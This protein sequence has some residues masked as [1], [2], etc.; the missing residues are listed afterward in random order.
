MVGQHSQDVSQI[1]RMA[2]SKGIEIDDVDVDRNTDS[3]GNSVVTF[4]I[5]ET[6]ADSEADSI[7]GRVQKIENSPIA[8]QQFQDDAQSVLSEL[9]KVASGGEDALDRPE[10]TEVDR[11]DR[12]DESVEPDDVAAEP[13]TTS[14]TKMEEKPQN[15]VDPDATDVDVSGEPEQSL[16]EQRRALERR[17]TELEQQVEEIKEYAEALEGLSKL[18]DSGEDDAD[19][20]E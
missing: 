6:K 18:V 17:V 12:D 19:R 9:K 3:N 14:D 10:R 8:D 15:S 16:L 20:D 5:Y 4:T 7:A 1:E 11:S 13:D 2:E